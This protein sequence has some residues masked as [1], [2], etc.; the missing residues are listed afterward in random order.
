MEV[1]AGGIQMN[2]VESPWFKTRICVEKLKFFLCSNWLLPAVNKCSC[3]NSLHPPACKQ[4]IISKAGSIKFCKWW[5]VTTPPNECHN[6]SFL[7][8][9]ACSIFSF[10]V[11][12][13][14]A[15]HFWAQGQ[16]FGE[17]WTNEKSK[18][19]AKNGWGGRGK[20][21]WQTEKEKQTKIL[22]DKQKRKDIETERQKF[23]Y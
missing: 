11:L 15:K 6:I 7:C 12:R 17:I 2:P 14:P 5:N 13:S 3:C 19:Y 1:G 16:A 18:I 22:L 23:R 10:S 8:E 4:G 20:T 9:I 21:N